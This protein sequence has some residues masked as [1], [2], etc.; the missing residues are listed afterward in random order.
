[1]ADYELIGL[2]EAGPDLRAPTAAD[3]GTVAGDVNV[4]GTVTAAT[5][6]GALASAVTATT[7]P[8]SD[9]STKVA[10]TAYVDAS[11]AAHDSLEEVLVVGNT[12]GG[13]DIVVTSGDVLTTNTINETTAASGVTIDSVLLKDNTITATTY[14]GALASAVTATTQAASDNSTKVATT[15]YVDTSSAAHDS[16]EE[17]LVVG[18][19][20]GT[21]NLIIDSGQV[22]TTNTINETTA[23]SGVTIDSVLIK[24]NT[25]TATTYSGALASTVTATTQA[26]SDNST[27]V[28]TTAYVDTSSAAHDS[29]PE[30]LVVGNTTGGTDLAVSA[31]DDITFTDTSKAIFGAGSDLQIYHDGSNSYVTDTSGTGDLYVR[32]TNLRL[33]DNDGTLFLYGANN[34]ATTVYY[35]GS[36]RLATTSTGIDVTGTATMDG[37]TVDV[38]S[39]GATETAATLKNNGAGANTKARLDF[40]AAS[41]RYAG[42]SGGYG[43]SSP[44]MSFDISGTDVLDIT[45]TGIDV[46]GTATMDG[47]TVDDGGIIQLTKNT[48]SAGDS[49]GIIE[50]HDED[51]AATADAGKFQLQAFRGADKDAPDFKLI[52]SDAG[53]TLRTRLQVEG[54][55]DLSLYEDT[56]TTP[57]FFWDS[58][59]ESLGIG[60]SSPQ[61]VLHISQG[62][63]ATAT[64][65]RIEN[66]DTTI[67]A[68]ET[69]NAIEFYTNDNSAGGTGVTGKI[70]HVSSNAGNRYDLTFSTYDATSLSEAMR[71]D[72]AGNVLVGKTLA[73]SA[74][75]GFE[76]KP[77]GFFA[78]TRT[79]SVVG[80]LNRLSTDGD[81]LDFRKAGTTVGTIGVDSGDNLFIEG[82]AGST[83]SGLQFGTSAV[84]PHKNGTT[85]NAVIDL[86]AA[87]SQFKDLYLSGTVTA[88]G[89]NISTGELDLAG[90]RAL[91][92]NS[93]WL[94]VNGSAEFTSGVYVGSNMQINGTTRVDGSINF[95][96]ANPFTGSDVVNWN[97]AFGWGDHSVAGYA[98]ASAYLPLAGGTM[99]GN[100][101]VSIPDGG[102]APSTTAIL[103]MEGYD[104]RG[105]GIKIR[106]NATTTVGSSDREWFIGTGYNQTGFNIGYSGTGTQ[107]DYAAQNL[108]SIT[109]TGNASIAGTLDVSGD[110]II[111]STSVTPDGTLHVYSGASGATA[112]AGTNNF[113]IEGAEANIG[114]SMIGRDTDALR[115]RMGTASDA[116]GLTVSWDYSNDLGQLYT[117]KVGA[118]LQLGADNAVTN[119]TLSG[120]SGSE[121]ATF[122]GD[123]TTTGTLDSG[124]LT[125]TGDGI[126]SDQLAVGH[127]N[128]AN[129]AIADF[130]REVVGGSLYMRMYNT[131]NTNA[132]TQTARIGLSPDSRAN[133]L[134]GMEAY[135]INSDF[136]TGA[137]R[138]VGL[139]FYTLLN[140]LESLA[141]TIDH[142]D[143]A[144]FAGDVTLSSGDITTSGEVSVSGGAA[145]SAVSGEG[146]LAGTATQGAFLYGRGSVDDVT[147]AN[148]AGSVALRIPTGTNDVIMAGDLTA[149]TLTA[150]G[151]NSTNWNTAFGWGDHSVAG[152]T[153]NQAAGTGLTGTTTLSLDFDELGLG[154]ALV[155]TDHLIASNNGVENRQLISSIPLSIFNDD[156]GAGGTV[157][158]VTAGTGMTQ[159]GTST[160]DPTLNVIGGDGITAN[161]NDIEVDST[162][163]RTTGTQS[164]GGLKTFT[165]T[166]GTLF[167]YDAS[168]TYLAILPENANGNV[169]MRFAATGG[170]APDL[171][172]KNDGSTEIARFGNDGVSTFAGDINTTY[173]SSNSATVTT[174][175]ITQTAVHTFPHAT[176]GSGKY[177]I[178]ATSAGERHIS[179]ILIVHNGTTASATE[180]GT[181]LTS[182]S[183]YTVDVDI[184]GANARVLIT[185]ASTTSTVYKVSFTLIEA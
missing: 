60:N 17:V 13:T 14:T 175:S 9:N 56:G 117:G 101:T 119:L 153:G 147:I 104:G 120:A 34:A 173:D 176:Y 126:I 183:L 108:L 91:S 115:F 3:T 5:Y 77:S 145:D 87:A 78:A 129:S 22:L 114:M 141:L 142:A 172:I 82:S 178:Q 92:K 100:L 143:N 125:V 177:Q 44:E 75:E 90:L 50:F 76:A 110:T 42:I 51:G 25:V 30:V 40:F 122:A 165:N 62:Q 54:N 67:N 130:R 112:H 20:S 43:A 88:T 98:A 28:A 163:I 124:A 74:T 46:T 109:T 159:T 181:I 48:V 39:A 19:T 161:A 116:T 6:T 158:A 79:N 27:K 150:T 96:G 133:A 61:Q 36:A 182:G 93:N 103:D 135:K 149:S 138:D 156:L 66:T 155:G 71:I 55:G 70:S 167:E 157:T 146:V 94:Y 49:L 29:L 102:G 164:I 118:E 85:A 57:K 123:I 83:H 168:S 137:A 170:A 47:L 35:A 179:D 68:A 140:G 185:S 21:N 166:T 154:G 174:T 107:T 1:M 95:S 8:V 151:G 152:Y 58:S 2:N 53:G 38:T 136:S 69:A 23:A 41:T 12:T 180:Y 128:F 26:A 73:S 15:A 63:N 18:N 169:V 65:L 80:V 37:L 113:V 148:Y 99:T 111:G 24:D 52:G 72:S 32:G 45:S 16:L 160:F 97:T 11:S 86:G 4:T 134:A 106:D 10:T 81:I 33:T 105:A 131:D 59:T 139:K 89:V 162:V 144:T 64:A 132:L 121:L 184:S 7:Q 84:L 171:I 127:T 31:G